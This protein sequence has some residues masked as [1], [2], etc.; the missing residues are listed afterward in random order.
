LWAGQGVPLAR[1]LPA[2][3]L[4]GRLVAELQQTRERLA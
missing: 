3:Q 2:A 1:P 4:I